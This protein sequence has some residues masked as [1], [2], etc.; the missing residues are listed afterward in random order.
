M[1]QRTQNVFLS[2]SDIETAAFVTCWTV[3]KWRDARPYSESRK[4]VRKSV[5]RVRKKKTL[6]GRLWLFGK[7]KNRLLF[8]RPWNAVITSRHKMEMK[9]SDKGMLVQRQRYP[10]PSRSLQY[11]PM[12]HCVR[13][14]TQDVQCLEIFVFE[15]IFDNCLVT[16]CH[17]RFQ[18]IFDN[19]CHFWFEHM[20]DNCFVI[21]CHLSPYFHKWCLISWQNL[22]MK[23]FK[24]VSWRSRSRTVTTLGLRPR[25]SIP[26]LDNFLAQ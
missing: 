17:F 1:L 26:A 5:V 4:K 9:Y 13:N 10:L 20:F 8:S 24:F 19:F 12:N 11:W 14:T 23:H 22:L 16:I 3:K 15:N 6:L 21:I 7:G 2:G 25:A 18:N